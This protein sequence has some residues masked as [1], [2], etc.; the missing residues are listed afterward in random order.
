M[1]KQLID[2]A[3]L[4]EN[5]FRIM[6]NRLQDVEIK[7]LAKLLGVGPKSCLNYLTH[8]KEELNN[9]ANYHENNFS[10][11]NWKP[12]SWIV[13]HDDAMGYC[14]GF[15]PNM[16][17][18][19]PFSLDEF[20]EMIIDIL[21]LPRSKWEK[22]VP[23]LINLFAHY[24]YT[25]LDHEDNESYLTT[26]QVIGECL[27]QKR[28]LKVKSAFYEDQKKE[29]GRLVKVERIIDSEKLLAPV[30]YDPYHAILYAYIVVNNEE[31]NLDELEIIAIPILGINCASVSE[32]SIREEPEKIFD[33]KRI[34]FKDSHDRSISTLVDVFGNIARGPQKRIE[35]IIHL[36]NIARARLLRMSVDLTSYITQ[37][38]T[39]S[40]KDYPFTLKIYLIKIDEI[41]PFI[42]QNIDHVMVCG[43]KIFKQEL[44]VFFETR[45]KRIKNI[46]TDEVSQHKS[47]KRGQQQ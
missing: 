22:Y 7:H 11:N 20:H 13:K 43:S 6:I 3:S 14:S 18:I 8:Y 41:T 46:Y 10:D 39:E 44:K 36:N 25:P 37:N 12:G 31:Y 16:L 1:Q 9:T 34:E 35:V 28:M 15:N 29:S 2:K 24:I 19:K 23:H 17:P 32:R 40:K 45:E 38:K 42:I 26:V 5:I 21:L 47:I 27:K 4:R 30:F 33:I